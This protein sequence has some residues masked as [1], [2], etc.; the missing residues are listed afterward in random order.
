MIILTSLQ[1]F[2]LFDRP[3]IMPKFWMGGGKTRGAMFT[4]LYCFTD[5]RCKDNALHE[6]NAHA[7][8][9]M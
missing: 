3:L 5:I 6:N 2:G 4:Q 8:V 9:Y 7:H 1:E